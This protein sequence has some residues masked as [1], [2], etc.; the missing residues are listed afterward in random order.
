[1]LPDVELHEHAVMGPAEPLLA[2]EHLRL[3]FKV[4]SGVPFKPAR[5][6]HAVDD[7][8]FT[9]GRGQTLGLAGET[10]CGK[11]TLARCVLRLYDLDD[12][13][14]RFMG[15]DITS[16]RGERLRRVRMH[17][18]P[19]FQD[20]YSSLNPRATV[21]E[22]VAEPLISHGFDDSDVRDRTNEALELV[23]L[24][25]RMAVRY[26][27]EFSG[28]QRQRI[29][30]ARAIVLRPELIVADEPL[31]ALDVSIQ[32]QIINLLLDLQEKLSLTYIFISHDLRVV[33]HI[34][35]NVAIMFLGK[36]VE[37]GPAEEVCRNPRHPYTSALLSAVP[38]LPGHRPVTRVLLS[39]DPPSPMAP[40]SGCRFRTRCPRAGDPCVAEHPP[41]EDIVPGHQVACYFP[42]A[43]GEGLQTRPPSRA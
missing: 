17:M 7:V 23:G 42:L 10:G 5:R 34:S 8:S 27:H 32:A 31:S 29:S 1:M 21:R 20:P 25:R 14:I 4:P 43:E 15:Q 38:V 9:V 37:Y 30:I 24:N 2:A 18:Q 6:V 11:S 41:L 12:G 19:I 35:T 33:R 26:P 40:P 3:H 39:G 16:L 22:I 36:I 28:G 13:S